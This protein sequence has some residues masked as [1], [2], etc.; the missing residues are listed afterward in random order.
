MI[1]DIQNK[2]DIPTTNNVVLSS[3]AETVQQSVP[4]THNPEFNQRYPHIISPLPSMPHPSNSHP[5]STFDQSTYPQNYYVFCC[6]DN[7]SLIKHDNYSKLKMNVI[8][9]S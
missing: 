4:N 6:K 1:M 8:D 9:I 7:R 3:Y 5:N 2:S